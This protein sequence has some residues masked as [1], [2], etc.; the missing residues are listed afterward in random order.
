MS[1]RS[2]QQSKRFCETGSGTTPPRDKAEEYYGGGIPWV[3]SGELRD[4]VIQETAETVTEAASRGT[5]L[6][7]APRGAVLVAMYGATVGQVAQLGI[8]ATTNQAVCHRPGHP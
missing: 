3:K 4:N 2:I 6:R 5:A 7:L 1:L 8:P